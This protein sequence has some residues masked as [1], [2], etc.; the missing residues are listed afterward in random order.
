MAN[1]IV[2][3]PNKSIRLASDMDV[4]DGWV[5]DMNDLIR[6][7]CPDWVR[8]SLREGIL[9]FDIDQA[10]K[11]PA[12]YINQQPG[13]GYKPTKNIPPMSIITRDHGCNIGFVEGYTE[14]NKTY[15]YEGY[16]LFD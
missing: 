8:K 15:T 14:D 13:N 10:N 11:L 12:L 16:T 6:E 2:A 5:F 3:G 1:V 7:D 9:F 4:L